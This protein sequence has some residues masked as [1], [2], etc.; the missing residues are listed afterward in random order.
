M[1]TIRLERDIPV[2][3]RGKLC[4]IGAGPGGIAAAVTA[5]RRGTSTLLFDAHTM[6]GGMSTAGL[7][8]IFMPWSDGIH[9]LPGGFGRE[10]ID[11]L[12][13][14]SEKHNYD[15]GS[16]INAEHL[17]RI[18]ERLLSEAGVEF[19][20]YCRLA[21]VVAEHGTLRQAVFAGPGGLFAV[22]ADIFIDGTG[23]GTLAAMAGAPFVCG[24]PATGET[25]PST[26]CSLW[27]G[28]DWAAYR[29]GGAFSHND[30][31][32]L[33]KLEEAFRSGELDVEDY[34]HTGISRI[35]AVAAA[36]N[37]SHVFDLDP[38]DEGSLTR[39]LVES[40]RLLERYEAFY[41]KHIAGF[42]NAE[43]V[44]SGSLLGVREFRRILGD[45]VLNREDYLARRDFPDEIG[46][47][48]FPAD[49]HPARPGRA[50]LEAHKRLFSS[51]GNCKKGESYGIPYRILL[52]QRVEN[53]LI[54]GRCVSCDRAV[55]A[56]IRV[57]PGCFI[58][59]QAAGMAGA[60]AV[61]GGITP[62]Q[63]DP[64]TLR[65][66]LRKIGGYFH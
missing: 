34:H 37:L 63:V 22:E 7:V 44:G 38:S 5:A 32:M 30:N 62:R 9:F 58:T 59:G 39:G 47:Y 41:R 64:E 13:S 14:E 50:E 2:R 57:I 31:A 27:A 12:H 20:Y 54:C 6:P 66:E 65:S 23:D 49:I 33:G 3:Y 42:Q 19:R 16:A 51:S 48:N 10:V 1:K 21:A 11:A 56:S 28:F 24:D 45:Y 43:I 61:E 55:G 60:I 18:Y 46:R 29:A 26:L 36:G 8:P 17:K 53:L 52:P 15:C 40:R 35:S 25:M 4:I